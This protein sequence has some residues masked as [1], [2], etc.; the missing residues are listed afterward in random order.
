MELALTVLGVV[1]AVTVVMG[2]AGFLIN[3]SAAR[4]ERGEGR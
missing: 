1:L 4:R 2:F 3:R